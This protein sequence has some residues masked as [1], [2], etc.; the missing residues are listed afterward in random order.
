LPVTLPRGASDQR[1][2]AEASLHCPSPPEGPIK[3]GVEG[4]I[5][6]GV[7]GPIKGGIK[8]PLE[9]PIQGSSAVSGI[10]PEPSRKRPELAAVIA[11]GGDGP[12][13]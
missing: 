6:G 8:G 5:K 11:S 12:G 2:Q 10:A 1:K 9:G 4:P 3:G 13:A 7:E